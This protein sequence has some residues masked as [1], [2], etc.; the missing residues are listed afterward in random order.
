MPGCSRVRRFPLLTS[1]ANY[2]FAVQKINSPNKLRPSQEGIS[3][4][5]NG[6]NGF[7]FHRLTRKCLKSHPRW[8]YI[9]HKLWKRKAIDSEQS[10][11][12]SFGICFWAALQAPCFPE[13]SGRGDCFSQSMSACAGPQPKSPLHQCMRRARG[14][15]HFV[16]AEADR[17][18]SVLPLQCSSVMS[19]LLHTC[20]AHTVTTFHQHTVGEAQGPFLLH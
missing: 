19:S 4:T 9:F 2:Y 10:R 11:N 13:E 8:D 18:C 14:P 1:H 7:V 16:R 3:R 17:G 5:K 6:R 12:K 20:L 15:S